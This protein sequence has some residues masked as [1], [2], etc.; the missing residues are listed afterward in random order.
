MKSLPLTV[1]VSSS[2]RLHSVTRLLTVAGPFFL[3]VVAILASLTGCATTGV[4]RGD[5]NLISSAEE[6]QMGDSLAVEVGI[7]YPLLKN[8]TVGAYINEVGQR[9]ASICDRR[10]IPYYFSV[11]AD[12]EQVNAFA[13]PGGHI[14]VYAGLL[15]EASNEAELAGVLAHE[16]GHVVARHA[17]EQLSKEYGY[18]FLVSLVLGS[19]PGWWAETAANLF[20]TAGLLKFSRDD[21]YEGDKFAVLYT[22]AAG[23][24]PGAVADFLGKLESLEASEPGKLET[25]LMT[26]PPT[27][28]RMSRVRAQVAALSSASTGSFAERYRSK[29]SSITQ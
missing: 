21:E 11:I 26:H 1:R 16:V 6:V 8:A 23:Y 13:L 25:L 14:Y 17:M 4:N 7:K 2:A 12:K 24:S 28:E 10:D 18:D 3:A 15:L 27:S 22:N 19:Q 5:F 29:I 9:V 20:G